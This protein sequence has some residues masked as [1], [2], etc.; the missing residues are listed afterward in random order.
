MSPVMETDKCVPLIEENISMAVCSKGQLEIIK[1]SAYICGKNPRLH[2][3]F[4]CGF[5][6]YGFGS[7][8]VEFL[9][10]IVQI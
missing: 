4:D 6:R 2:L 3:K 7:D 1:E 9:K 10:E 8:D 5:G